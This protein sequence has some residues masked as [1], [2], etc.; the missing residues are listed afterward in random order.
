MTIYQTPRL[1]LW[2]P[3]CQWPTIWNHTNTRFK[4]IF[5]FMNTVPHNA[6]QL[7]PRQQI[8]PWFTEGKRSVLRLANMGLPC[9]KQRKPK[10][11]DKAS[12]D[13]QL[14]T[15]ALHMIFYDCKGVL[16]SAMNK[17]ISLHQWKLCHVLIFCFG[18]KLNNETLVYDSCIFEKKHLFSIK[19]W[20]IYAYP[21][22]CIW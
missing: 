12:V 14:L 8:R 6:P 2:H 16:L 5:L 22:G 7:W 1:N 11:S 13:K 10:P 21:I 17:I 4:F 15:M 9:V 3:W 19:W 20:W 18:M